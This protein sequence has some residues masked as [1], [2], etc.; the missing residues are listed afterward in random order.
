MAGSKAGGLKAA[1]TIKARHGEDHYE[2]IGRLGG[3]ASRGGGF[4]RNRE[5][6]RVAGAKGGAISKRRREMA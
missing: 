3:M 6:A 2:R 1:A 4:A 5:L